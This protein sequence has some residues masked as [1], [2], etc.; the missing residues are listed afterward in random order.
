MKGQHLVH[1]RPCN[2]SPLE[3]ELVPSFLLH[4]HERVTALWLLHLIL[5]QMVEEVWPSRRAIARGECVDNHT[6]RNEGKD[7]KEEMKT[8]FIQ[9]TSS[10]WIMRC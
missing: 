7:M 2:V 9:H 8:H 3:N 6:S 1:L 5:H 10:L 4:P